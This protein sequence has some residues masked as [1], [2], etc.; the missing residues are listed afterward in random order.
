MQSDTRAATMMALMQR[1]YQV[2][3]E[4]EDDGSWLRLRQE[5]SKTIIDQIEADRE[6][7]EQEA[8][9]KS[10]LGDALCYLTNQC[11]ALCRFL[12][13]GSHEIDNKGAE[14][15]LRAIAVGRAL[16]T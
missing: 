6:R 7:L 14:R 3:R 10:P 1:L 9:P 2:E 15:Q 13:D 11:Q 8:L 5:R 12:E 16:R 4:A